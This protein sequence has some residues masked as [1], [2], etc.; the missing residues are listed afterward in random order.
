MLLDAGLQPG[1]ISGAQDDNATVVGSNPPQGQ[2][3]PK[4]TAVN[5]VAIDQG[6]NGNNGGTNFFGG[7]TGRR[8]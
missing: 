2:Q 1:Q 4:G 3:V 5:L 6:G 8:N 7:I